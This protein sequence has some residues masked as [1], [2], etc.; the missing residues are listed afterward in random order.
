MPNTTDEAYDNELFL[1]S[2][3]IEGY[4]PLWYNI[5]SFG[6]GGYSAFVENGIQYRL[7]H[8]ANLEPFADHAIWLGVSDG[9]LYNREA[10]LYDE[11]SGVISRNEDYAGLN[12]LF[13]L[14]ID[15]NK[16][17]PEKA[18]QILRRMEEQTESEDQFINEY[19]ENEIS[20]FINRLTPENIEELTEPI[21]STRQTLI[22]DDKGVYSY[23]YILPDGSGGSGTS[24]VSVL[25]PEGVTGLPKIFSYSS[26]G[27]GLEGLHI[28]TH[29]LNEDGT[30]TFVV[31]VPRL[32]K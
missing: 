24:R 29:M 4:D 14:P 9:T 12:A 21:E 22:P 31:C 3:Y 25:F 23:R 26:S 1:V 19:T 5:F 6:N 10:F 20:D 11:T 17:D 27:N 18:S 16:A 13:R 8:T 7:V 30:V 28:E 15:P 32:N 2:P